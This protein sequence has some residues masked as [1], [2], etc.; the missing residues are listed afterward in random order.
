MEYL[1]KTCEETK[2]R[3]EKYTKRLIYYKRGTL[4]YN[5]IMNDIAKVDLT[6]CDNYEKYNKRYE[7]MK[8]KLAQLENMNEENEEKDNEENKE[9]EDEKEKEKEIE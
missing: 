1:N 6:V 2:E 4:N 7:A 9:N 3:K 5:S 8:Q